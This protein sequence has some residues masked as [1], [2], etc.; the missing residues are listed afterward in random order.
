MKISKLIPAL[1]VTL[2]PLVGCDKQQPDPAQQE[3]CEK[4]ARHLATVVQIE[5]GEAVPQEQ[6]DKMV[7]AT[8]EQCLASPPTDE[9]LTCAMAAQDIKTMKACDPAAEDEKQ[10]G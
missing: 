6:V 10:E 5:Q 2:L 8:V 9:E 3:A 7:E 1:L 4:F